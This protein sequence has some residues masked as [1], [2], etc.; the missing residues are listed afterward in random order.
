MFS[1]HE[2]E[3]LEA[4]AHAMIPAGKFFPPGGKNNVKKLEAYLK[5]DPLAEKF[6]KAVINLFDI[7]VKLKK[8]RS[9]TKLSLN[10]Q[11]KIL[12]EWLNSPNPIKRG[13]AEI[14]TVT[15]KVSH[16]SDDEIYSKIGCVW[17]KSPKSYQPPPY[18]VNVKS[19][20]EDE[21]IECDIV[22][23]GSGAG[24]AVVAKELA[25]KGF[26]V[27]IVEE[28]KYYT[29]KDFSGKAAE[30]FRKFYRNKGLTF[31]I[32]NTII[33]I[34]MGKMVGGSTAINTGTSWRTPYWILEKWVKYGL[35]ELSPK[36]MEKYFEKVETTIQVEEAKL[37]VIGGIAKV[38]ER[39]CQRLGL[40]HHPVKRNAP[41]CDGQGVCTFGCPTDAKKSTNISY[42]PLALKSGALLLDETKFEKIIIK[43]GKAEG[44]IVKNKSG[45]NVTIR[46]K[47]T[48]LSCG[49][50]LTPFYLIEH[51]LKNKNI[52]KNLTIHPSTSV[53]A[54]LPDDDIR[55]FNRTPQGYCISSFMN[56][57]ILLLH[58]GLPLDAGAGAIPFIGEKFSTA[59]SNFD[60]IASFGVMVEDDPSGRVLS[61]NHKPFI[62]YWLKKRELKLLKF[63]TEIIIRIFLEAGADEVYPMIRNCKPIRTWGDFSNFLK[64]N[65]LP[66]DYIISAFH[67]LG[68]CR[69][70]TSPSNSVVDMNHKV[71]DIENLFIVD[72]SVVPTSIGVNPQITIMALATR[73]AEKIAEAVTPKL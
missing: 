27:I 70:G 5:E 50:I 28:G 7:T 69:M 73:A 25:E 23:I 53:L 61:L 13:I 33:P 16:F 52:G 41:D 63:G 54:Y 19:E 14:I 62:F 60:K 55:Q 44:I 59:M 58:G 21:E 22:V 15:L 38:I 56:I 35:S 57:G 11:R 2:I 48:V 17:D 51:K 6:Y 18:M 43:N 4:I 71:W 46:A 31:A 64:S 8:L 47:A 66:S 49:A 39:G 24:G 72:G 26:G 68:T 36:N 9:F 32:G 20:I 42:I 29:R 12:E 67:P 1:T 34:P 30:S 45:K 37:E 3:V 65:F 10:E 40:K